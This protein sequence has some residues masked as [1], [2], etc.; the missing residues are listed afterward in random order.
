[1]ILKAALAGKGIFFAPSYMVVDEIKQGK[2]VHVLEN[3][4]STSVGLYAVYPHS[5]FISP[6]VRI[7]IDF[8]IENW[9]DKI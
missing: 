1:M 3:F 6:K 4:L 8:L 5:H 7:F 9:R 2:L